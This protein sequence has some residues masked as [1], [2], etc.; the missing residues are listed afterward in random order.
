MTILP[1][2]RSNPSPSSATYCA[3][4]YLVYFSWNANYFSTVSAMVLQSPKPRTASPTSCS[5][6]LGRTYNLK[7][8]P[9]MTSPP[10]LPTFLVVHPKKE[11]KEAT[12]LLGQTSFAKNHYKVLSP[13]GPVD[14][15]AD[16]TSS[17]AA[18][19]V[20]PSK[21]AA[22]SSHLIRRTAANHKNHQRSGVMNFEK[23]LK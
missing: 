2:S 7:C 18:L 10:A 23:T 13:Q 22:S 14:I 20:E 8:A 4:L 15:N 9:Q 6:F 11:R 5:S 12:D 1:F 21:G 16:S 17:A 19:M 3:M